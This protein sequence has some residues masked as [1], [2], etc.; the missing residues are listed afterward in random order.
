[1]MRSKELPGSQKAA[2]ILVQLGTERAERILRGMSEAEAVALTVEIANLPTLNAEQIAAVMDEFV[3]SVAAAAAVAQGGFEVAREILATRVS[4]KDADELLEKLVGEEDRSPVGFLA[5]VEPN[6]VAS[7]LA[8]EHPQTIALLLASLPPDISAAILSA[9][10]EDD[11]ADISRRI[12]L[13]D[14]VEPSTVNAVASVL[15]QKVSMVSR[16]EAAT[17]R[18]GVQSL[19]AILNKVEQG[20]ERGILTELEEIDGELA[21]RVRSQMFVFEDIITLDDK[22]LQKVLRQIPVTDL[23]V[24]LKGYGNNLRDVV[25]RNLSERAG[26]DLIEQIENLGPVRKSTVEIARI[27]VVKVIRELE[28]KGEIILARGDEELIS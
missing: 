12:A 2:A 20:L 17:V 11:Q 21:D 14:S 4:H 3:E 1:M 7:F 22:T 10:P 27:G 15:Q 9:L 19:V 28:A 23:A 6:K 24:S 26:E 8:T 18:S 16:G 13:M 25:M 5:E